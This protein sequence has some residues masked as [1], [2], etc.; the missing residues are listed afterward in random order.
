[1]SLRRRTLWHRTWGAL[2]A[3]LGLVVLLIV[4]SGVAVISDTLE[5]EHLY[6]QAT[7]C[8]NAAPAPTENCIHSRSA[9]VAGVVIREEAKY[10][11]FTLRLLED[12]GL[13]EEIDMGSEGPLL[14]HLNPGDEVNLTLWRDYTVAVAHDGTVQGTADTPEGGAV[15]I[16][17]IVLAL[18]SAGA[19][20]LHTGGTAL[21]RAG[22]WARDG[23]PA[24]LVVRAKWA[25]GSALCALPALFLVD[26]LDLGPAAEVLA[27]CA[28][29][30]L[31]R[32]YLQWQSG[33]HR[34]AHARPLTTRS[35]LR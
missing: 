23:L 12:A 21:T 34:G 8:P 6:L 14:K 35:P 10:E 32:W 7:A 4:A 9:R 17:T 1:M 18:I 25:F 11:E 15:F 31:V 5:D 16:T 33:R 26:L 27:W 30:P 3:L 28:M 2:A 22:T 20:L 13:P 19:F 24:V 29:V